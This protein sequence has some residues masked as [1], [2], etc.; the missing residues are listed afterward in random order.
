MRDASTEW[1]ACFRAQADNASQVYGDVE[2]VLEHAALACP[3]ER[4][5]YQQSIAPLGYTLEQAE[6]M[7]EQSEI[8]MIR[9]NRLRLMKRSADLDRSLRDEPVPMV[10][11]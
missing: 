10:I 2:I 9:T 8:Q 4:N 11:K 3:R 7:T 5:A 6:K 1:A